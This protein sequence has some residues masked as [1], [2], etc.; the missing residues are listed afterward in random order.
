LTTAA[1][2]LDHER[3][4]NLGRNEHCFQGPVDSNHKDPAEAAGQA[5]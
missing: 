3:D 1:V 2:R 5:D 4:R